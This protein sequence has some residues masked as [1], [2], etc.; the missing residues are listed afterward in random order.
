MGI[1]REYQV[2]CIREGEDIRCQY[3]ASRTSHT[4]GGV[5]ARV[6]IPWGLFPDVTWGP[7]KV[8]LRRNWWLWS[9][10]SVRC[11]CCYF[12]APGRARGSVELFVSMRRELIKQESGFSHPAKIGKKNLLYE[13]KLVNRFKSSYFCFS[14]FIIICVRMGVNYF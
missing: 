13:E 3:K 10:N 8:Y 5:R 1:R 2:L 6:W 11:C 14:I 4:A 7:L 12:L 9:V